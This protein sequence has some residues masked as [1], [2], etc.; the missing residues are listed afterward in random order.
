MGHDSEVENE[1]QCALDRLHRFGRDSTQ[2]IREALGREH[3]NLIAPSKRVVIE[4][5]ITWLEL[6][7]TS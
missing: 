3:A 4:L 2:T 5:S 6:D 7:V 1:P